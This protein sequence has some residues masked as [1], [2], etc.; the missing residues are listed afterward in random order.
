MA[1]HAGIYGRAWAG[2]T[3]PSCISHILTAAEYSI[4]PC[5]KFQTDAL[6]LARGPLQSQFSSSR[7]QILKQKGL[8]VPF[9]D[10]LKL[11]MNK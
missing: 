8:R 5:G 6:F 4:A 3:C 10:F 1:W 9:T 11:S 2:K 7:L